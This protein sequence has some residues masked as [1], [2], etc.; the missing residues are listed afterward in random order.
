MM[1]SP[2]VV[3][4]VSIRPNYQA[5]VIADVSSVAFDS[6]SVLG[7]EKV[8][9][10]IPPKAHT[11]ITT[12]NGE[13]CSESQQYASSAVVKMLEYQIVKKIPSG[14]YFGAPA[15]QRNETV[16]VIARKR[17]VLERWLGMLE[18]KVSLNCLTSRADETM[19]KADLRNANSKTVTFL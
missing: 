9:V 4:I 16:P 12:S 14:R 2:K 19:L 10:T 8:S 18:K 17:T 11:I 5:K 13:R 1:L 6:A 15:K 7:L 3:M